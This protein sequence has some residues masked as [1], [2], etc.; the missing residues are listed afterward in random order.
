MGIFPPSLVGSSKSCNE[1]M[2]IKTSA[3]VVALGLNPSIMRRFELN[4]ELQPIRKKMREQGLTDDIVDMIDFKTL[5]R[6]C[7]CGNFEQV[8]DRLGI[9]QELGVEKIV[10]GP[11]QGASLSGVKRLINTRQRF[12]SSI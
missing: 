12:Y 6:F 2:G 8:F 7:L 1:H 5:M 9:Y 3:A 4:E 11:P 10:F